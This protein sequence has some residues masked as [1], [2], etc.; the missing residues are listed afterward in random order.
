[1]AQKITQYSR[2]SHHTLSGSAS[3]TF[4]VPATEDF[5]SGS[6]TPQDLALSE[7][8]VNE[9]AGRV[10][11]RVGTDIKEFEFT[12]ATFGAESLATTLLVG[13]TTGASDIIVNTDQK[14]KTS[15]VGHIQFG[16]TG[17]D[18]N[19]INIRNGGN[20]TSSNSNSFGFDGTDAYFAATTIATA[21]TRTDSISLDP[22]KLLNG[23]GIR[24]ENTNTSIF[25]S[26]VLTDTSLN[27]RAD[28]G[29]ST[30]KIDLASNS[31]NISFNAITNFTPNLTTIKLTDKKSE[32]SIVSNATGGS[33]SIRI[34]SE[35]E[36]LIKSLD[37]PVEINTTK[38]L[39]GTTSTT[40]YASASIVDFQMPLGENVCWIKAQVKAI[41]STFSQAYVADMF[42]G[43]RDDG[44]LNLIGTGYS[45]IEYTDFTGGARAEFEIVGSDIR[46]KA[47]GQT[48]SDINWSG[49]IT[50]A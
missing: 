32:M 26:V 15:G 45:V 27:L 50:F 39:W 48:G 42:G 29:D 7:I 49:N 35:K 20:G 40:G 47:V 38:F 22:D 46:V 37:G 24:A 8:G 33:A 10:Y 25:S 34:V 23:T 30:S 4:S 12:G 13:N 28:S 17:A 21:S 3:A 2:I 14:I 6:W 31:I 19:A 16:D 36:T 43:F 1:M 18:P 11:I 5:T 41:T 9:D 44:G